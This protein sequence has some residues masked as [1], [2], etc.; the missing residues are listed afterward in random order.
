MAT[1]LFFQTKDSSF[2]FKTALKFLAVPVAIFVFFGQSTYLILEMNF[3]FFDANGFAQDKSVFY[4]LILSNI[5]NY[6]LGALAYLIFSFLLG[7]Y[8]TYLNMTPFDQVEEHALKLMDTSDEFEAEF[9]V[10]I[11][12]KILFKSSKLL[13]DYLRYLQNYESYAP[14]IP[15]D[16]KQHHV[17][18]F[19]RWFLFQYSLFFISSL[20]LQFIILNSFHNSLNKEIIARGLSHLITSPLTSSFL[21]SQS[22]LFIISTSMSL[23]LGTVLYLF[24]GLKLHYYINGVTYGLNRDILKIVSGK[25][26]V[27]LH[28][29]TYDPAQEMTATL[30]LLL[31]HY[32]TSEQKKS[33]SLKLNSM[34]ELNNLSSDSSFRSYDKTVDIESEVVK[35]VIKGEKKSS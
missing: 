28:P 2:Y 20:G 22:D 14:E 6:A 5:S 26:E 1:P 33:R 25:H 19:D 35:F 32:L 9:K 23:F 27:R 8:L 34:S 11:K 17:S 18:K 21:S 12:N 10:R 29:R 15:L 16:L 30:N 3:N 24:F 4:D 13:F 7:L 31:N